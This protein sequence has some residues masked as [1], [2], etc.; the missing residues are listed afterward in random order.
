MPDEK[1]P[2]KFEMHVDPNGTVVFHLLE[3]FDEEKFEEL[4]QTIMGARK[5]MASIRFPVGPEPPCDGVINLRCG[6]TGKSS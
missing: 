5:V 3:D 2:P 4:R 6:T 1:G